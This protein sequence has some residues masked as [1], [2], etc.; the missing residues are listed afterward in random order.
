MKKLLSILLMVLLIANLFAGC[1]KGGTQ[2]SSKNMSSDQNVNGDTSN[3]KFSGT[4]EWITAISEGKMMVMPRENPSSNTWYCINTNGEILF[5][6]SARNGGI[7]PQSRFVNGFI[8]FDGGLCDAT[9]KIF[10]PEDVGATKF[11]WQALDAGYIIAESITADYS[12]TKKELGILNTNMEWIVALSER[13]YAE[14][15]YTDKYTE[16]LV[17]EAYSQ[18]I[19]PGLGQYLGSGCHY[20]CQGEYMYIK[21]FEKFLNLKTGSL[22]SNSTIS[23]PQQPET[24]DQFDRC[25]YD[26]NQNIMLDLRTMNNLDYTG[27]YVNGVIPVVFNNKDV[28]RMYISA[29]NVEGK[30]LFEP[31]ELPETSYGTT[32]RVYTDGN[33]VLVTSSYINLRMIWIYD[34]DGNIVSEWDVSNKEYKFDGAKIE[35]GVIV[36]NWYGKEDYHYELFHIDLTEIF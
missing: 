36:L 9:G 14:M 8:P 32:I 5:D 12:G 27:E 7:M 30:L 3:P 13:F 28:G 34:L 23:E 20:Y 35:D 4:I 6:I 19:Y 16:K 24:W 26:R 2:D 25:F 1:G 22:V 18:N 31:K 21:P 33:S 29:V 15:I 10:Y 17:F 11:Y